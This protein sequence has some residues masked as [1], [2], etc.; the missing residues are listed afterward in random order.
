[1]INFPTSPAL[2][3]IYT[4]LGRTWVWNGSGWERQINAGQGCRYSFSRA[5]RCSWTSCRCRTP[6]RPAGISLLTSEAAT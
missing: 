1:M 3:D 4:Y 6:S 2:N 5:L